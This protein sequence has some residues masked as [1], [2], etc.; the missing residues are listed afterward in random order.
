MVRTRRFYWIETD[1]P[2]IFDVA[3][4]SSVINDEA[5]ADIFNVEDMSSEQDAELE[6]GGVEEP[7]LLLNALWF[8]HIGNSLQ[9]SSR[10]VQY[11]VPRGLLL[12][13]PAGAGKKALL[14][15]LCRRHG[16]PLRV[17]EA[18]ELSGSGAA[19]VAEARLKGVFEELSREKQKGGYAVLL[20]EDVEQVCPNMQSATDVAESPLFSASNARRL[21]ALLGT[22]LDRSTIINSSSISSSISS[23]SISSSSISS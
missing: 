15:A 10:R 23:S 8:H 9:N 14:T 12:K 6:L 4:R 17:L 18:G 13:G 20:L 1:I 2:G 11:P 5:K 21:T 7:L 3:E 16:V 22:F 19:G